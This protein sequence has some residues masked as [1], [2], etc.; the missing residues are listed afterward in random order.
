VHAAARKKLFDASI[1]RAGAGWNAE[2]TAIANGI[3]VT[4]RLEPGWPVKRP[5]RQTYGGSRT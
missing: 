4:G 2:Q 5:V 1:Q 3:E